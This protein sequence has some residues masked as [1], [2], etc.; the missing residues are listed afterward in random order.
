MIDYYNHICKEWGVTPTSEK[1]TGYEHV[2][3]KLKTYT[4]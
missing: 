4:K 1:Y 2:E 3:D